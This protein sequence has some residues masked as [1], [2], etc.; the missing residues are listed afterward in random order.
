MVG[1]EDL[2]QCEEIETTPSKFISSILSI[3]SIK[4]GNWFYWAERAETAE[5]AEI[6]D[7][8]LFM[9]IWSFVA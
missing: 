2:P 1:L 3:L 5:R 6:T 8:P 7:S 4:C 9:R